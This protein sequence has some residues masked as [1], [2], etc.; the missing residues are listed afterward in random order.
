MAHWCLPL[1]AAIAGRGLAA[2]AVTTGMF[3]KKALRETEAGWSAVGFAS[4]LMIR[5]RFAETQVNSRPAIT[6]KPSGS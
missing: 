4:F 5:L 1:L 3:F 2:A 6:T